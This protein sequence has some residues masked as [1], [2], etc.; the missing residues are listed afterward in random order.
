MEHPADLIVVDRLSRKVESVL[1]WGEF[2]TLTDIARIKRLVERENASYGEESEVVVVI[3]RSVG[4]GDI[5]QEQDIIK[6]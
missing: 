6:I 5:L 4:M 3:H 2:G 1:V